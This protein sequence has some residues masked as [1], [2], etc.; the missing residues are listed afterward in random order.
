VSKYPLIQAGFGAP[1]PQRRWK[2][3]IRLILAIPLIIWYFL[4]SIAAG[5]LIVIGWFCALVLGRL[6]RRF[7]QPLSEYVVFTTRANSY[8][9]LMNDAY[10]PFSTKKDFGVNVDIPNTNVSRWAVLLRIV[11]IIPAGVVSAL[12]A[13]GME[14]A[15]VFIWLIVLVK[16]EM[17]V[18][19]FAALAALLRYQA[20]FF[21]YYT[22][23][24]SKYPGELF[25]DE[26]S[27][28][29]STA[30]D[31]E[32]SP[33]QPE[34]APPL[35]FG[36]ND[37]EAAVSTDETA[38][39]LEIDGAEDSGHGL[40]PFGAP[41]GAP[42]QFTGD[43]TSSVAEAAPRTA[44]IVLSQASKRILVTL[45]IL[46]VIGNGANTVL[47]I[48]VLDNKSALTRLSAANNALNS[49]VASAKAAKTICTLGATACTQQY[50]AAV[51][52][53]FANFDNALNGTSFPSSAHADAVRLEATTAKFVVLLDTMKSAT[54]ISQ[55][56]INDLDTLGN[57][58]D[59]ELNQVA[60]DLSSAL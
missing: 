36:V 51:A 48:K 33:D 2:V 13:G 44:R 50:F 1:Q 6:P 30:N 3:A 39:S 43:P 34:P 10:P 5:F 56:Q 42:I 4:I 52:A 55:T 49:D 7:V 45:L 17:P 40:Q 21:A 32:A 18:S 12:L 35:H 37:S 26:P 24:T 54:T 31:D 59:T 22:M 41:T 27:S 9:Y 19:L 46:G 28:E 47:R 38:R 15:A 57:G 25:G 8:L 20:R 11:L 58:F 53:A 16:G 60:S 14:V 29:T 23:L